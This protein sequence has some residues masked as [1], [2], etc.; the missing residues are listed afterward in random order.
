MG[1]ELKEQGR[2]A[3]AGGEEEVVRHGGGEVLH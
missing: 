1:G 2:D 3:A